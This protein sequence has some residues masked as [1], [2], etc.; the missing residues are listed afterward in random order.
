MNASQEIWRFFD[1]FIDMSY[2]VALSNTALPAAAW[3][4]PFHLLF[5]FTLAER[6]NEQQKDKVPLC[7]RLDRRL[8]KCCY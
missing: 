6:K 7:R 2:A 3:Y 4:F 5:D 1:P 8:R